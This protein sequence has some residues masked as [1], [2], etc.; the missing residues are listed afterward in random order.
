M[1]AAKEYR[2]IQQIVASYESRL[3]DIAEEVFQQSPSTGGWSYSEVYFHIFD[4]SL[5]ALQTIDECIEG[6]GEVKP[7]AFIVKMILFFG[8]LPPGKKYKAPKRLADRVRKIDKIEAL[9]MIRQFRKELDEVYSKIR[10]ADKNI[11]T[12]H[13]RMGYLNAFQWFRF[14]Q[15]HLNHHLKQLMRIDKSF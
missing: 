15:I 2:K 11:K 5:L 14:V 4:A 7:T 13:P 10:M 3:K 6:K 1:S 9:S 12:K 8:S